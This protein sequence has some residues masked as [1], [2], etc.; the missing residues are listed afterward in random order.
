[1]EQTEK[2]EIT[3]QPKQKEAFYASMEVPVLFYGGAKGGGKSYLVRAREVYRRMKY[4]GTKGLIVRKTYPELL[5]NHIRM[6]WKEYP[7]TYDWF[8]KGEKAIYWPN[9]SITEFSYMKSTDDVY[10][11]QGREYEDI[12]IDE[13]TQHAE[14]VFKILR[15]SNRTVDRRIKPSMLLTGNPGGIGHGWVKRVFV[16]RHFLP[17]EHPEQF[18]FV[19]AKVWDNKALMDA[20][21]DY[22]KRLQALPEDKRRAYLDGDWNI[23]SGQVFSEFRNKN[24][25]MPFLVP[26]SDFK[27]FMWMDWGYSEKSA[28]AGY[29]STL[30]KM[31]T[32]DGEDFHR[33]VTYQEW[34][35]NQKYP[36]EW[37]SLIYNDSF[38]YKFVRGYTDPSMHNPQS[39]GSVSIARLFDRT[40]K[41]LNKGKRWMMLDKGSRN[42][43]AR[44]ATVHN[45]LSMAPDGMPYWIITDNC[46][47]LIRTLPLLVH[48]EHNVEDVD[49]SMEDHAY[50]ACGYGLSAIKWISAGVGGIISGRLNPKFK[51][52]VSASPVLPVNKEGDPTAIDIEAFANISPKKQKH[53]TSV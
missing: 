22:I 40:W 14:D 7:G 45:W 3:L 39:D 25:V 16:D 38:Q 47:N 19:Q 37:A 28:F 1:M 10:T 31:K 6:F 46:K 44:V 26:S 48:D 8:N 4:P 17:D 20:D 53:W 35:G 27:H 42:R 36:D 11:Y 15:S 49:T 5:S 34:Y 52:I 50:D 18:G 29:A 9:G 13:I 51:R 2:I 32:E 24:H 41:K 43:I 30:I 21:P 12:S 23:F 33:V